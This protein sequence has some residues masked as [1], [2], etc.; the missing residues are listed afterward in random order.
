MSKTSNTTQTRLVFVLNGAN[1][2]RLGKRE[3]E[4]YGSATHTELAEHLVVTGQGL[5]L[6]VHVRQTDSEAEMI[7]WLHEAADAMV[8]V[9]LNPGAWTHYSHAIAD[10]ALGVDFLVEVHISNIFAREDF[11]KHS[12]IS[13]MADGVIA[14][15]GLPGYDLALAYVASC[16]SD[17]DGEC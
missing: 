10:A 4:F 8:P 5:G 17:D 13:E 3:P 1:L 2:G 9:V 7:S 11:R 6:D 16:Q 12:V 15:L 14:G